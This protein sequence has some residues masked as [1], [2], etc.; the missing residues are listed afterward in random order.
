MGGN[1]R[2]DERR[3][4][5]TGMGIISTMGE[6]LDEYKDS[7]MAGRSGIGHWKHMDE[8]IYSKIGGDLSDF[9]PKAHFARVGT[10]YPPQRVEH[11]LKLL[12]ATPL[13]GR[14]AAATALQAFVDA[15]LSG[16]E[17]VPE[18]FGHILGGHMLNTRYLH[19]NVLMLHDE[20][21]Y[22]DP[23][24]GVMFLDTD[25][26]AVASEVLNLRGPSFPLG[27]AC[28]T[29]ALAIIV[30]LDMIR[31]GRADA[32]MVTG[33]AADLDEVQLQGWALV[34]AISIASFND[35]PERASRPFDARREGFVPSHASGSVILE[36]LAS[37]RARGARIYAELLGGANASDAARTPKPVVE[38]QSYAMREALRDAR[39]GPQQIN[40]INAHATSTVVGDVVEVEAIRTV[41]GQRACH[42]PV[43]ATKS[44]IG[45]C[46]PASGMVEFIATVL[47]MEH[48]FL[49]PTINLDEPEPGLDLDFVPHQARPYR[50]ELAISNSFGF[51][52]LNACLVLGRLP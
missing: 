44:M 15:G 36:S 20:P 11:A 27:G 8:R 25:V 31:S 3:V 48:D 26:M 42:I 22:I 17:V 41:F 19:E 38:G 1:S 14:L 2:K 7:L 10:H 6:S 35:E 47:Q 18:R 32:V 23:L 5:V 4:V 45:H 49:H 39:V 12:R 33:G 43:N 51:G 16:S 46:L 29:S 37:A 34:G 13:P 21:D 30:G 28:A 24:F 52:S 40:Y 9:D 50:I